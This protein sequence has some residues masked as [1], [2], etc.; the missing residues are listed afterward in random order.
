M[1]WI[2]LPINS[3]SAALLLAKPVVNLRG[4][5]GHHGDSVGKRGRRRAPGTLGKTQ[6]GDA[7]GKDGK[8][9]TTWICGNVC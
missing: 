6:P 2:F 4:K 5:H 1:G 8:Q 9:P 7:R 3:L